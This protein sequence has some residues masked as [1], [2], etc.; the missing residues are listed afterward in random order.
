MNTKQVTTASKFLS[1]VLRHEPQA[2]ELTLDSEGWADIDEL[3]AQA[4]KHNHFMT[5]DLLQIVVTTNDKKRFSISGNKIRAAQGHST[6]QVAMQH[7]AQRPPDELLHGTATRFLP[8]INKEGLTKQQ[9]Q[10]V[11]MSEDK[12]TAIAVG[13]RYGKVVVLLIDAFQMY[14]NGHKFYQADNGVWLTDHVP[15]QYFQELDDVQ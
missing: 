2:I 10:H 11:H 3:V 9:R 7:E 6:T 12:V 15:P 1:Y 8:S 13:K 4:T 5:R 14:E